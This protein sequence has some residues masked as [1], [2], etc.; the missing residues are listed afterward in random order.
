[1]SLSRIPVDEQYR[2]ITE[3]R[4]SGLSD[5]QWCLEHDIKP[6]TFYN[7]VRRIRQKGIFDIPAS[8]KKA[9]YKST[10][11]QEV[12]RLELNRDTDAISL[13]ESEQ[14]TTDGSLMVQFP[15]TLELEIQGNHVRATN[16]VDPSLLAQT[17]QILKGLSC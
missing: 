6:G 14:V 11:K 17:I 1:M 13:Y 3:C 16:E 9:A 10:S 15:A 4:Q 7:W 12:V 5:Y 2:L 8:P